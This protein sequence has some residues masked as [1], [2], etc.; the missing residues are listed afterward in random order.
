MPKPAKHR[1]NTIRTA[2]SLLFLSALLFYG[3]A[4]TS[5]P[6]CETVYDI[7]YL[8]WEEFRTPVK[9]ESVMPFKKIGNMLLKDDL[10]ILSEPNKGI[11]LVNNSDPQAPE[12]ISFLS[13]YAADQ[14]AMSGDILYTRSYV[15]LIAIDISDPNNAAET[16]RLKNLFP[17]PLTTLDDPEKYFF[18]ARDP[19]L[20]V[21]KDFEIVSQQCRGGNYSGNDTSGGCGSSGGGS[22]ATPAQDNTATP[23]VKQG[24]LANMIIVDDYLY[25]ISYDEVK[26]VSLADPSAP[27]LVNTT[28]V[29]NW[30]ME[31]L[32]YHNNALYIGTSVGVEILDITTRNSPQVAGTFSHQWSCDPIVVQGEVAYSTLRG[33]GC[34]GAQNQLDILDVSDIYAPQLITSVEMSE[35]YGLAIDGNLLLVADGYS[36]LKRLNVADPANPIFMQGLGNYTLRDIIAVDGHA[37][38]QG[39]NSVIQVDYSDEESITVV[40][41]LEY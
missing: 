19:K 9:A 25:V 31:T 14:V 12:K 41:V 11:H 7:E 13:V 6:Y 40:S 34:G 36:G 23:A 28:A 15:D 26:T 18:G 24:S 22:T 35:P 10:L 16:G 3:P 30:A 37:I 17:T 5:S 27:E 38:L 29:N 1:S 33:R 2:A 32:Y 21:V 8:S 4:Q 39:V 20:G